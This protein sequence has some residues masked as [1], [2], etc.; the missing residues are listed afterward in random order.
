[1]YNTDAAQNDTIG[2]GKARDRELIE[3][4]GLSWIGLTCG[5]WYEHSLA[6]REL[7]GFDIK[8]RKVT[9]FDDGEQ[10]LNCSTWG[11]VGRAVAGILSLPISADEG[12]RGTS[13]EEYKNR[14]L[15]VSS[16][17]V[18][19]SEMWASLQRVTGT[20]ESDWEVTKVP[21]KKRFEEASE[22]VKKGNFGMFGRALYTRYFYED[23]GLFEKIHG[24]ENERLSL[25]REDLDGATERAVG[26]VESGYWERYGKS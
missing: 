2:P 7:F 8:E 1:M 24:L 18:S 22:E 12:E 23:A 25:E 9:M 10:K 21:A 19:Q 3:S 5:F 16:F 11:F 17:A 14:M 6:G 20:R 15:Y 13:L 26:L 4:L